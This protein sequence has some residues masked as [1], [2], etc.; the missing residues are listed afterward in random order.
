[1]KGKPT[2]RGMQPVMQLLQTGW[3]L[4]LTEVRAR[5]VHH[6]YEQESVDWTTAQ[7]LSKRG[8][9][10]VAEQ[11]NEGALYVLSE[12]GVEALREMRC[13]KAS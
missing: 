8:W 11:I 7:A 12:A 9:L 13:A 5:L 4:E 3:K 6:I 10:G 1:M 2:I